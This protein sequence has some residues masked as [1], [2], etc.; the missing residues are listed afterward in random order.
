MVGVPGRSKGCLTCRKRRKGCDLE[1]PACSQ[2][3]KAGVVCEGYDTPRV[4]VVST[5]TTRRAG[6]RSTPQAAGSSWQRGAQSKS[7][8]PPPNE[9]ANSITNSRLL[10][11]PESERR[12]IDLF[13]EG[14]FPTG[15]PIPSPMSKSYTCSWTGTARRFYASDDSLRFALWANALLMTGRREGAEWMLREG[16]RMYGKA[17]AGLRRSLESPQGARRDAVIATVKL[18]SMFEAFSRLDDRQAAGGYEPPVS[19]NWQ[20]HCAGEL[21][22]FITRT[23]LAHVD[24]DSHDVFADERVDMSLS[25]ILRRKRLVFS[26]P[27]WKSIPWQG[28]PRDMKDMLVDVLVDMPGLV[29]DFDKWEACTE[30]Q[31]KETLRLA[32][33]ERCWG[34]DRD[35]GAWFGIICSIVGPNDPPPEFVTDLIMLVGQIHGMMVFWTTSMVLFTI[36]HIASGS[37]A[38]LLPDRMDPMFFAHK[39]ANAALPILI[40]PKAGL[41]GQQ[42]AVL[43]LEILL[44]FKKPLD[45]VCPSQ[46]SKDMLLASLEKLKGQLGKIGWQGPSSAVTAVRS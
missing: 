13:W 32:L 5:P 6:Y 14:Y 23:P 42:S 1:K 43:P 8:T 33:V 40:Q 36:L 3:R 28:V 26:L 7:A 18:V 44:Q 10:G 21:A 15:R 41:Y 45:R 24:G 19:Q 34:L 27:E 38:H 16:S 39:L 2:C 4:F 9:V 46:E 25:G 17:L 35:L 37:E 30:P 11:R 31:T 20:R 29:E 12:C 22:L